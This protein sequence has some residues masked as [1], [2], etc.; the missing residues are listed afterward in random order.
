MKNLSTRSSLRV[1]RILG[2]DVRLHPSFVLACGLAPVVLF[3]PFQ[4]RLLDPSRPRVLAAALVTALL[5][6]LSITVHE[7]GHAL[8]ARR[9]G[10]RADE[11]TLLALGGVT[12]LDRDPDCPADEMRIGIVGPLTSAVLGAASLLAAALLGW[13]PGEPRLPLVPLV[14]LWV[15]WLNLS[16]AGFNMIPAFPLDGGRVLRAALWAL[17]GDERRAT[18]LSARAGQVLALLLMADSA[19]LMVRGQF[20]GAGAMLLTGVFMMR[21]STVCMRRE[22][23]FARLILASATELVRGGHPVAAMHTTVAEAVASMPFSGRRYILVADGERVEGIVTLGELRSVPTT[24]WAL[25][26][27]RRLMRPLGSPRLA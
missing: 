21:A 17:L 16:L 14:F 27:L 7:L 13:S 6:F 15:G 9:L 3:G 8:T 20:P 18:R 5:V 1:A 11:V 22:T 26:P 24:E 10:V 23:A 25:T 19:L 4:A 2:V 12:H